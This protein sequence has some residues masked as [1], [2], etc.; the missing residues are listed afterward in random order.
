M[1][2]NGT[3][4]KMQDAFGSFLEQISRPRTVADDGQY[5]MRVI[6]AGR[7]SDPI[8]VIVAAGMMCRM[9]DGYEPDSVSEWMLTELRKMPR[10]KQ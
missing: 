10:V 9:S 4:D 1:N 2:T 5:W 8:A 7:P 3:G 6:Q